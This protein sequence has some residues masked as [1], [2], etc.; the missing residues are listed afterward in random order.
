[1]E[2]TNLIPDLLFKHNC[3]ILPG[4]GGFIA[5]FKAAE[6]QPDRFLIS[7]SRK[8]VAFNQS[9]V[10][11]DGLLISALAKSKGISYSE[12]EKEVDSFIGFIRSRLDKYKNFELKNVG[13]LYLN[14][15]QNMLFVPYQG[16]NFLERSYGLP[17]VKVKP[18]FD[19][20]LAPIIKEQSPKVVRMKSLRS[21][22]AAGFRAA[23]AAII[24]LMVAG[25]SSIY[26][27]ENRSLE[28]MSNLVL[29]SEQLRDSHDAATA[30]IVDINIAD[31]QS[32]DSDEI[33]PEEELE[34]IDPIEEDTQENVEE[35]ADPVID[36]T[37]AEEEEV[38]EQV[39]TKP[40]E[41]VQPE[42]TQSNDDPEDL[43]AAY[44]NMRDK[45]NYYHVI[46]GEYDNEA[47]AAR[48]KDRYQRKAYG[49]SIIDGYKE[50]KYLVSLDHFTKEEHAIAYQREVRISERKRTWIIE[51]SRK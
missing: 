31:S 32:A 10:E 41:K 5:N 18:L 29:P 50:G 12:A 14:N 20:V 36:E 48:W 7:P 42:K 45:R 27:N 11:N 25:F 16:L 46:I 15:E 44:R 37:P 26:L 30:S 4:F 3:V 9:L 34:Q 43:F 40:V 6:H 35:S 28:R 13:T 2:L 1:M 33:H 38:V 21:R 47:E 17:D 22:N 23:A 51:L 24:I 8:I 39:Q 19:Q 49:A